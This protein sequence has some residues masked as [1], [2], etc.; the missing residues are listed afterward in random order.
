MH[1]PLLVLIL[2]VPF[3]V[4]GAIHTR[5]ARALMAACA[6]VLIAWETTAYALAQVTIQDTPSALYTA[7]AGHQWVLV[8]A[9]VVGLLVALAKQGWASMWLANHLPP[10][11]LPYVA[12]VLGFL[13]SAATQ[14][15]S[16]VVWKTALVNGFSA[17]MLAVFGHETVI[18]GLRGGKEIVPKAPWHP[19]RAAA[20]K[21]V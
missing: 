10:A 1:L 6:F 8:V 13:G 3:C 14:V 12:I 19:A 18:E 20:S 9:L 15:E 2:A 11:A 4:L 17:A 5:P 7:I 16:G 21:T